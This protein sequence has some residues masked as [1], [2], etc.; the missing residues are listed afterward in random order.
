[1]RAM[2]KGAKKKHSAVESTR[3][4]RWHGVVRFMNG[5]HRPQC[6]RGVKEIRA[7]RP[8]RPDD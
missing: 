1:M 6:R 5:L 3:G 7:R 4:W 2:K 8:S